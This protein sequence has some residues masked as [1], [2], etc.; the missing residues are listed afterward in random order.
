MTQITVNNGFSFSHGQLDLSSLFTADLAEHMSTTL[1]F[2]AS[3]AYQ[4][5]LNGTGFTYDAGNHPTDGV[6]TGLDGIRNGQLAFT[7]T[8]A[9][10]DLGDLRGI[11][12][13]ALKSAARVQLLSG[14]DQLIGADGQDYFVGHT[15][16][17]VI[18]GGGFSDILDGGDGNDHIYGQSPNGGADGDDTIMGGAGSD[19]IN[20]NAGNDYIT[21]SSGSD[22]I[23]G[24][25]GDDVIFSFAGNDTVNG[26]LGDDSILG[27]DGNDLLRGGQ[28]NDTIEG[29]TGNDIV[30]GDLGND[31]LSGGGGSDLL[32]GGGGADIFIF[33][34]PAN[35]QSDPA[36]LDIVT[37]FTD[38]EDHI[39]L[40]FRP[41]AIVTGSAAS[42]GDGFRL[43]QQLMIGHEGVKEVAAIQIGTDTY[44]F[45]SAHGADDVTDTAG[46]LLG[47]QA[48]SVGTD[49]FI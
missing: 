20:G 17:D 49:D 46:I 25:A 3:S 24:G 6:M 31:E 16:H 23:F 34:I 33:G 40:S 11:D 7:I 43:A 41:E 4:F 29:G 9:S 13:T 15:G 26:N 27:G 32:T 48:S 44:L 39:R 1:L 8:G 30:M 45:Y 21:D 28:G 22:R 19:Y 12:Q 5:R 2:T 18:M 47:T 37:D 36:L 10:L 38:G 14:D 42:F 35:A